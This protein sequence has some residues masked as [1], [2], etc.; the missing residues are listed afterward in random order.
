[1]FAASSSNF[2]SLTNA[3]GMAFPGQVNCGYPSSNFEIAGGAN[4]NNGSSGSNGSNGSHGMNITSG[5][6]TGGPPQIA[7]G[8]GGSR[9]AHETN[10]QQTSNANS[11]GGSGGPG[12]TGS[13]QSLTQQQAPNTAAANGRQ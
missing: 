3:L 8:T 1:M 7:G 10:K 11:R 13:A 5:S 2:N 4:N 6:G 12:E 9:S